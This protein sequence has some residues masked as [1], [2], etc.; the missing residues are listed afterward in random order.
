MRVYS[1]ERTI[2][3]KGG[4]LSVTQQELIAIA[5]KI[6]LVTLKGEPYQSAKC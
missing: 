3:L 4:S 6:Y 1:S 2:E 5:K